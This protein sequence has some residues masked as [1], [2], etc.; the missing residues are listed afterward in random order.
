DHMVRIDNS[1]IEAKTNAIVN[2]KTGDRIFL[3][4]IKDNASTEAIA[5]SCNAEGFTPIF[6]E[7][8]CTTG[9]T[10]TYIIRNQLCVEAFE[11]YADGRLIR[12]RDERIE[13]YPFSLTVWTF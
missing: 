13:F 6:Q 8:L 9:E 1:D 10:I 5:S 7:K 4:E 3:A 12:N 2:R 11:S